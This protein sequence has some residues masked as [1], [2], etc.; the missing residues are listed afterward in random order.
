MAYK[1]VSKKD[2]LEEP[3]S[4]NDDIEVGLKMFETTIMIQLKSAALNGT[5]V[6]DADISK[7]SLL[8]LGNMLYDTVEDYLTESLGGLRN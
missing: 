4:P 3:S 1:L 6:F 8:S 7:D 5:L 2:F